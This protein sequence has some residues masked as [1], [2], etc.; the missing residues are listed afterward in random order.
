MYVTPKE[1][2][3]L[4][5]LVRMHETVDLQRVQWTRMQAKPISIG[6]TVTVDRSTAP[7]DG[8][9]VYYL[10][11]NE[12]DVDSLAAVIECNGGTTCGHNSALF[13]NAVTVTR[14]ETPNGM[15]SAFF[16]RRPEHCRS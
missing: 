4:Y 3:D 15:S 12:A 1:C 5:V 6:E 13:G 7:E 16:F 8:L 10:R 11:E 9:A 2:T 14:P